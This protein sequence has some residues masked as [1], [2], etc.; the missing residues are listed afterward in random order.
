[1]ARIFYLGNSESEVEYSNIMKVIPRGQRVT[2][3]DPN[4]PLASQIS[5]AEIVIE[6]GGTTISKEIIDQ[7]KEA[8]FFQ[9]YGVGMN[10]M[11]VG[12]ALS[13]GILVANTPGG[14]SALAEQAILLMLSLARQTPLWEERIKERDVG[15]LV[16]SELKGKVLGIVGIG[17]SGSE[18]AKVAKAFGMKIKA[19]DVVPVGAERQSELGLDSFGGL[20]RLDDLLVQS[21]YIS[22]H[23]PLNETTRGMIGRREFAKMKKGAVLVNVARGPIIDEDSLLES[24]LSGR[25][26]GAGLDVFGEE[27]IDPGHPILRMKNVVFSPH[28]AGSTRETFERRAEMVGENLDRYI[29]GRPILNAITRA[30]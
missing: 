26:G 3:Y 11:D 15:G 21:D 23:V 8:R 25:I 30:D 14:G 16:G 17:S 18:L 7:A 29:H 24:L 1:M 6:D 12:Y 22:I 2:S 13:K 19:I 5:D 4:R 9:R 10:H 20:D 27:P 28:I